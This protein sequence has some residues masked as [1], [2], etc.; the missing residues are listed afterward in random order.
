MPSKMFHLPAFFQCLHQLDRETRSGRRKIYSWECYVETWIESQNAPSS[1]A[2]TW[3]N[4]H[5]FGG[6]FS[7]KFSALTGPRCESPFSLVEACW[8]ICVTG[9]VVSP[10]HAVGRSLK[11]RPRD[12]VCRDE[13]FFTSRPSSSPSFRETLLTSFSQ[14]LYRS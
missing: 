11:L 8:K 2:G 13:H 3:S 14:L 5:S 4:F 7:V 10:R 12:N 6:I 9:K 1:Y